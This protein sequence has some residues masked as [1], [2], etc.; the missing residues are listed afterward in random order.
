MNQD[1]DKPLA[2]ETLYVLVADSSR[3]RLFQA[4]TPVKVLNEVVTK[5]HERAAKKTRNAILTGREAIMVVLA[6]TKAMTVNPLK[7]L[8]NSVLPH[9]SANNSKRPAMKATLIISFSLRPR[10]SWA[11][12]ATN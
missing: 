7:T 8:R 2:Q 5:E 4:V 6:A 9:N 12:C 1:A 10:S 11:S 3:A